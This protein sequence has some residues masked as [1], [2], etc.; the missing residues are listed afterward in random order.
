MK[1]TSSINKGKRWEKRICQ[2]IENSG[3][4]KARRESG[5]GS[6]KYKG[7]IFA[8]LPFLIEAKNQKTIKLLDWVEQAKHQAEIGNWDSNKWALIIRNPR[9]SEETGEGLVVIDMFEWFDLLK[10]N[11]EPRIKEPDKD[12][13]YDLTS[14]KIMCN[15]VINKLD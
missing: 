13:K 1:P 8:N 6:G 9:V 4:G 15:R 11:S 10:K 12:L 14:L 7:D 5:S 2:E 3:L